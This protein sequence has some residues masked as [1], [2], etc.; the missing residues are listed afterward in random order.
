MKARSLSALALL[1]AASL[2]LG[3]C[4]L[5]SAIVPPVEQAI[6]QT[7]AEAAGAPAAVTP[8]AWVPAEAQVIRIKT[9]TAL[10]STIMTFTLPAQPEPIGG[11]CTLE[12][13]EKLPRV[14]DTWWL[15]EVPAE[16]VSCIEGWHVWSNSPQVYAWKTD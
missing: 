16:G 15:H 2:S 1:G 14:D 13:R 7:P 11:E 6:Y 4:A 5:A 3:G 9:N 10:A 8:P 12:E